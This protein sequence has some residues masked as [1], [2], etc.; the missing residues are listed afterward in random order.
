MRRR[1]LPGLVL[2]ALLVGSTAQPALADP[3][4]PSQHDVKKA[5]QHAAAVGDRV[6]QLQAQLTAA[7]QRVQAADLALSEAAEAYDTA[8]IE[9][10]DAK[11]AAVAASAA[12]DRAG[13][14]L[15]G[16]E[17]QVG[18]LAAQT[19][20][21]G[22]PV[23]SL[24]VLLSPSGPDDVLERAEMM[25]T[26]AGRRQRDVQKMDSARVVATTLDTQADLALAKQKAA[27]DRLDQARAA[28][29]SRASAAHAALAA[30]TATRDRLLTQLA[31]ARRTSVAVERARQ[32]G[33]ERAAAERKAAAE[34]AAAEK[35]SAGKSGSGGHS[36]PS[37]P[38]EPSGGGSSSGSGS[39]GQRAVSWARGRLGLPYQWGGAGPGSYD[40]SGLTMKAWAQAGVYLPH[41]SRLQY[42]QAEK[43]SYGQLRPG[44]LIFYATSPSNPST[45]H[46]VTMYIGGGQMIEAPYTGARVRIVPVRRGYESMPYAGRP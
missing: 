35:A 20:R 2:T 22:G 4:Y 45:I 28:A 5:Q 38:S 9:L 24:D 15:D 44:D 21:G 19:Y 6:G 39:G 1:N 12:A 25:R 26:I 33:L 8:Q 18:R 46:H 17:A 37:V 41:S 3:V 31:R 10:E 7:S 13:R 14:R 30:E 32:T 23:A 36:S 11:K 42:A 27:T 16:A 29:Q 43:I 34:Q 40:C